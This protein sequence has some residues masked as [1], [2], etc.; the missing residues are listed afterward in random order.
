MGLSRFLAF[1]ELTGILQPQWILVKRLL[2][3]R[4]GDPEYNEK[5]GQAAGIAL[6]PSPEKIAPNGI[7]TLLQVELLCTYSATD[8][9]PLHIEIE[10]T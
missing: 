7:D 6:W 10:S 4:H 8:A 2:E 5:S 3:V 9:T 1:Y